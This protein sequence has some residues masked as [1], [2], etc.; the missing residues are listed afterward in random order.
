VFDEGAE[1]FACSNSDSKLQSTPWHKNKFL[2]RMWTGEND[3]P[4][5]NAAL[6]CDKESC[7]CQKR[8]KFSRGHVELDGKAIDIKQ[9]GYISLNKGKVYRPEVTRRIWDK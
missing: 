5:D 4:Q 7:T 9:G 6:I 1:T 8:I 2:T 3:S